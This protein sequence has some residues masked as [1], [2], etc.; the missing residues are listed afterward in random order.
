MR[1]GAHA[2]SHGECSSGRHHSPCGTRR[3]APFDRTAAALRT[4]ER[5]WHGEFTGALQGIPDFAA[6]FWVVKLRLRR[7]PPRAFF[8][9]AVSPA[10]DFAL[11]RDETSGRIILLYLLTSLQIA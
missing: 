9:S 6:G 5:G 11:R 2:G 1:H 10:P 4:G 3:R 7:K 8:G